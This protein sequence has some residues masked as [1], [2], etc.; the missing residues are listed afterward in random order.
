MKKVLLF[1]LLWLAVATGTFYAGAKWKAANASDAGAPGSVF[2]PQAP[3]SLS[4]G[5]GERKAPLVSRD[6]SVVEF[7]SRFGLDG[8]T[9]LSPERMKEAITEALR[10]TDPVKSQMLFARL[11][12]ELTPENAPVVLAQLRENVGGFDGMRYMGLLAYAWGAKDPEAAMQALSGDGERG[13]GG[14][15]N[16]NAVLSGWASSDP[17]KASAWLA[18]YEGEDKDRLTQSLVSG[19]A[20]SDLD[21]A[22]KYAGTIQDAGERA[23]SVETVAQEIIRVKGIEEA[24][25]WLSSLISTSG[26]AQTLRG[27][28]DAV[29]NQMLRSDPAKAAELIKQY[30]NQ[31]WAADA[32]ARVASNLSRESV[33]SGLAFLA[34]LGP[35]ASAQ[36]Y[37][38][39]INRWMDQN[40]GQGSLAASQYVNQMAP[41][42]AKDSAARA[43]VDSI[44]REDPA[45][46][47]AWAGAIQNP[48]TRNEALLR[49]AFS[50]QRQDPAGFSAWLPT[51]GLSAEAVQQL[52]SPRGGGGGEWRG[53]GDG[54]GGGRRGEWR[55]GGGGPRGG[56]GPGGGR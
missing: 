18:A 34:T 3:P 15:W 24:G 4:T 29:T 56:R 38:Q 19:L 46:A 28:L 20:K 2:S 1:N 21:A 54:G 32:A 47:I 33:E 12:E 9:P 37:R 55:G 48:T 8:S 40:D 27:A 44:S 6:D 41:G 31:P 45:S 5:S 17:E 16:Q 30:S 50:Y 42:A 22:F 35:E 36:G 10:E 14:R 49:A 39:V 53:R 43:I 51:S 23:R 13:P 25:R 52:S 11:M 7:L 26:D